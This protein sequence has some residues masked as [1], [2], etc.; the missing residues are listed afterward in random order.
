MRSGIIGSS[1]ARVPG[2][3]DRNI[4]LLRELAAF[5]A[6]RLP[7]VYRGGG[8]ADSNMGGALPPAGGVCHDTEHRRMDSQSSI[9]TGGIRVVVA[10]DRMRAWIETPPVTMPGVAPPRADDVFAALKNRNIKIT[11]AVRARVDEYVA[12]ARQQAAAPADADEPPAGEGDAPAEVPQRYLVAEGTPPVEARD[13]EF[14]LDEA[15]KPESQEWDEDERADYYAVNSILTIEAGK[16]IGTIRPPSDGKTGCDVYGNEVPPERKK[17]MPII[18]GNGLRLVDEDSRRVATEIAGYLERDGCTLYLSD[19]LTIPRDVDFHTGNIDSV[20]NVHI[21][22][23]VKPNFTVR[24]ARAL[25]IDR[26]VESACLEAGGDIEIRRGLFGHDAPHVIHAGGRFSAHI[27]DAATVEAGG[28]V[29]ITKEIINSRV[30]AWGQVCVERGAIIGGD[31]YARNGV[32]AKHLGSPSGVPTRIEVGTEGRVLYQA[33]QMLRKAARQ[34]EHAE[35]VR[36][37]VQPLL[38]NVKR[39]TSAQ[40]EQA[41]EL[42][43]KADE[44]ELEADDLLEAR[45]K[46]LDEAA[47]DDEAV[48]E[49]TGIL[50]AGCVLVFGL[51]EV[52]IRDAVRGPLRV[53][54]RCADGVTEI[55]I[56]NQS[57]GSALVL[58]SRPVDVSRFE[59]PSQRSGDDDGTKR[60]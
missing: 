16:V 33:Q 29:C 19:V 41:T 27:C 10:K 46:M 53:E 42:V 58:C 5:P 60:E 24:T 45:Q 15:Y 39:L 23:A 34:K 25:A 48:V 57:S 9:T 4:S 50:H 49:V 18:L 17:G 36:A 28:D 59:Q 54:T 35:N 14:E 13:G 20:V 37:R 47:P 30:R 56:V 7:L 51:H 31:T 32:K 43:C 44:I 22:G 52:E 8:C 1:P 21:R 3:T 12:L 2:G 40:R 38:A 6:I 11:D 55:V 26:D